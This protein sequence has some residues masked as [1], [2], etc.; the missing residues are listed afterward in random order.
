VDDSQTWT[1]IHEGRPLP[2]F[3]HESEGVRWRAGTGSFHVGY[4]STPRAA[5]I[6]ALRE[7]G[8]L[9]YDELLAPGEVPRAA[10][11]AELAALR[12]TQ[13]E[14]SAEVGAACAALVEAFV[15][16]DARDELRC[17]GLA[18]LVE[19]AVDHHSKHHDADGSARLAL[20]NVLALAACIA[21]TDPTNADHLRRF[22]A[23]AGVVPE[24]TR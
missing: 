16:A 17:A 3:V 19:V 21:K 10:L 7:A 11:E 6:D 23:A 4:G 1:A 20:R 22:C 9:E 12:E 18:R 8:A 24:I 2:V 15:P 5:V 14:R 13:A